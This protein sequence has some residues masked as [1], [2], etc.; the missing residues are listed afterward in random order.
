MNF[1][2]LF[3]LK[4]LVFFVG[5]FFLVFLGDDKQGTIDV[6]G[7]AFILALYLIALISGVSFLKPTR[8]FRIVWGTLFVYFFISVFISDSPG[9]SVTSLVRYSIAFMAFGYFAF[10][11]KEVQ[12]A[13]FVRGLLVFAAGC[14]GA[15]F[16]VLAF[17]R[18]GAFLPGMNLLFPVY[19]HNHIVDII[20]FVLP[21][22]VGELFS[23]RSPAVWAAFFSFGAAVV[24]SRARGAIV[25]FLAYG[26]WFLFSLRSHLEKKKL[27][28][29]GGLLA[30]CMLFV[31]LAR[32]SILPGSASKGAAL[33]SR[34]QYWSQAASAFVHRPITGFG[35][36]T[37]YLISRKYQKA[38][39][40]NSWYAHSFFLQTLSETGLI[41]LLSVSAA[42]GYPL[43]LIM[44][45]RKTKKESDRARTAL[46]H[47]VILVLVYSFFEMLLDFLV[48]WILFWATLGVLYRRVAIYERSDAH[49]EHF[50]SPSLFSGILGVYYCFAVIATLFGVVWKD[51]RTAYILQPHM[52]TS[53]LDYLRQESEARRYRAG[54][55]ERLIAF[56]HRKDPEVAYAMAT[57]SIDK[58]E[59]EAKMWYARTMDGDPHNQMYISS[60]LGYVAKFLSSEEAGEAVI[61]LFERQ[62]PRNG[63][64]DL[65]SLENISIRIGT[66]LQQVYGRA[67]PQW[68]EGYAGA[69][70]VLALE[71]MPS[72]SKL[73][74]SL[75]L[76]ARDIYPDLGF[77][78]IDLARYYYHVGGDSQKAHEVLE[79]C[80]KFASPK[81]Q[82]QEESAEVAP[83]G[84]F[85]YLF[86]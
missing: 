56:F 27:V 38:S 30:V 17:S 11:Q 34:I 49:G 39:S 72:D 80:Q 58:N 53:A 16:I 15:S 44:R 24:L 10:S 50:F 85:L 13:T 45:G 83:P 81:K 67:K 18:L 75:L 63:R 8:A 20:I 71:A 35:P 73:A 4:V 51:Y 7:V 78:H 48:I 42:V 77:I 74:E 65:F 12:A 60:Y 68:R 55:P 6:A 61:R 25:V 69:A 70:Y 31:V 40:T 64:S 84:D 37:Y 76:F 22:I 29:V 82:C 79:F 66:A 54:A 26:A 21:F 5:L 57:Y 59:A 3:F 14:V 46:F 47:A 2:R 32:P 33:Q 9:Y 28:A 52:V 43:F 1:F 41:G 36:G 19:G 86:I 62:W 23:A